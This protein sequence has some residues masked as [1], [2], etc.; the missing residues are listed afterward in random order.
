MVIR[1][2]SP[3]EIGELRKNPDKL[4]AVYELG[5]KDGNANLQKIKDF[6]K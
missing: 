2:S 3:I 1:P 5:V 6:I 4:Q